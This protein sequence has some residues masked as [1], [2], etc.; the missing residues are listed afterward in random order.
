[1]AHITLSKLQG[2]SMKRIME[3][4]E[5]EL[6]IIVAALNYVGILR[7]DFINHL[8]EQGEFETA[9]SV[10]HDMD[11]LKTQCIYNLNEVRNG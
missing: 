1:M 7:G 2:N 8:I 3:F 11:D 4:E 9:M 6:A 5:S 10:R